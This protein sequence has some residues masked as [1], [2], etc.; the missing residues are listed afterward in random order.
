MALLLSACCCVYGLPPQALSKRVP[1]I[2]VQVII[3]PR[4]ICARE[5]G[6]CVIVMVPPTNFYTRIIDELDNRI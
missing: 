6:T 2:T 1:S 4:L 3:M 5:Q